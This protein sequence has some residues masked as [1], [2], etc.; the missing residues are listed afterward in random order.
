MSVTYE[1]MNQA[2]DAFS[3][4]RQEFSSKYYDFLRTALE[5]AGVHNKLVQIKDTKLVGVF[6]ISESISSRQPWEIKF[7]PMTKNGTVSMKSKYLNNFCSWYENTIVKQL[8]EIAEVV[9]EA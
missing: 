4:A 6:K 9:G 2:R 1:E 3:K 5:E 8:Q 7:Y